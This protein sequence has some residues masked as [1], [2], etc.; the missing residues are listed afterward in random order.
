MLAVGRRTRSSRIHYA[1][2]V[3]LAI[4]LT[5]LLALGLASSACGD[6]DINFAVKYAPGFSNNGNAVSI[7]G[8]FKDGRMSPD[9]WEELGPRFSTAFRG[10]PCEIAISSELR[11][12]NLALFTAVDDGAREEGITDPMLDRFA[13]AAAG[14]SILVITIAGHA[15]KA[16]P[17]AIHAAGAA[18]TR[19]QM[20]GMGR[21]GAVGRQNRYQGPNDGNARKHRGND[22]VYEISASLY[23]SAQHQSVAIVSMAYKGASEKEALDKFVAKLGASFPGASCMAWKPDAL[24][25]EDAIRHLPSP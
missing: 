2:G 6:E 17:D 5:A 14:S 13:P 4:G 15:P 1:A 9:T 23:S 10:A 20:G 7:F 19:S 11:R 25:T 16:K 21:G 12:S 8:I 3:K 18:A 24:P 22:D